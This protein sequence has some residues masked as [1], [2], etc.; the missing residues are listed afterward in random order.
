MESGQFTEAELA[1]FAG[2]GRVEATITGL[3]SLTGSWRTVRTLLRLR[4]PSLTERHHFRR[5][6]ETFDGLASA[7]AARVLHFLKVRETADHPRAQARPHRL[8]TEQK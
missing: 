4:D 1:R 7:T 3:S 6:E 5:A 2:E 8:K